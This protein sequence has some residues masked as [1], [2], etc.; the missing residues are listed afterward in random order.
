[1][2]K[3]NIKRILLV[4]YSIIVYLGTD[5]FISL[6]KDIND[7]EITIAMCLFAL[8]GIIIILLIIFLITILL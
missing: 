8:F 4:L 1:M 2:K 6:P 5:T 7:D 3:L